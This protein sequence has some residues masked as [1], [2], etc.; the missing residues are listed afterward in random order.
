MKQIMIQT[1]SRSY[2]VFLGSGISGHMDD[3]LKQVLEKPSKILIMTDRTVY[4]L[5][6]NKLEKV[7][8]KLNVDV[9]TYVVPSGEASKSF[10]T[11][12]ACLTFALEN[13]MDRE[14]VVVAFG[15][16]VV[17][18]LAG[19]VAATFMR[20]IPFIQVPTTLLAHDSAVGGKVA[21]NHPLGKNMIGAFHQPHAIIYDTEFL[22]TLPQLEVRS[23]FAEVV[24]HG[25]IQDKSFVE[26]LMADIRHLDEITDQQLLWFIQKGIEVKAAVVAEDEKETGKRAFLN[27]GHT[28][29]HALEAELGYGKISHGDAV[30]CGMLFALWVSERTF[31]RSFHYETVKKWFEQIGFP[32]KMEENMD[33]K[34]LINRMKHD[35]K[36]LHNQIRMVL[37]E[38]IGKPVLK[39]FNRETLISLLNEWKT[40][41]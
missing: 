17:G 37:L 1:K 4:D 40:E 9:L 32:V 28:L 27:F 34:A 25:F 13:N 5:Y 23:G 35:K 41:G 21:I 16:G 39:P 11:Y 15:G 30:A 7:L 31:N 26:Q 8:K 18:D 22:K 3:L 36:T 33:P 10:E 24:K 12:Y 29:G 19:F 2:P 20:G 6:G 14:S 38:E